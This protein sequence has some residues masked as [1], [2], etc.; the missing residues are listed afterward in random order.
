LMETN[1]DR[2][3]GW[4]KSSLRFEVKPMKYGNMLQ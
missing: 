3:D 2:V 4:L 1:V